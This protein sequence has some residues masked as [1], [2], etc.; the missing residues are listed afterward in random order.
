MDVAR[1]QKSAADSIFRA[2]PK[3]IDTLCGRGKGWWQTHPHA[4]DG[5]LRLPQLLLQRH[6]VLLDCPEPFDLGRLAFVRRAELQPARSQAE[7]G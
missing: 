1:Q 6:A 4:R 5:G 2:Q 7:T 3:R